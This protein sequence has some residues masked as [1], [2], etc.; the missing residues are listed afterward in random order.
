[1]TTDSANNLC[2]LHVASGVPASGAT[3]RTLPNHQTA[4]FQA[5]SCSSHASSTTEQ[6][7]HEHM[8]TGTRTRR[9]GCT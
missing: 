8:N 3:H 2:M 1:M 9:Q 6:A 5:L 4:H 7:P